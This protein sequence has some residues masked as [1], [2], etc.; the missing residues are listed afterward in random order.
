[1]SGLGRDL[2]QV[3]RGRVLVPGEEGFE[4]AGA[5]WNLAVRQRV[6]A[7]VEVADAA[8]AA[9]L[10][11]FAA[12]AE[13][14]LSTRATGHSPSAAADGTVLV[15]TRAL[16]EVEI[17][18][19]SR[20]ARVGA[21]VAWQPVLERAAVHGLAGA[22]GSSAVVGVAGYTLG[23]GV[24]WFARSRGYAAH[25]VRALNV[26]TADGD[27][28]RVTAESN[29]D[30]FWALRGGGGDFALVT[31]L[32]FE[33]FDAPELFGGRM[34]WPAERS[35]AV[36]AAFQ[37]ATAEAEAGLSLWLTLIQFPPFPQV[38]EPLRGQAMVAVD[39]VAVGAVTGP[40]RRF[41]EIAGLVLDTRRPLDAAQVGEVCMEPT[42]P[43]PARVRG[44]LLTDFSAEVGEALLA[45]AAPQGSVGPLALVQIRHLGGALA[46]PPADAGCA[47]GIAEPYLLSLLGP[48]PTPEFE[49]LVVE[50]QA[51]VVDAMRPHLSGRK[52]FTYLDSGENPAAVFDTETLARLR[53]IKARRDP[54]GLFRS[55][56]PVAPPLG[57][58]DPSWAAAPA[59]V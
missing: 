37:E 51:A 27:R 23:G 35:A 17:D 8:D 36:I 18:V 41:D 26:V 34:L 58:A 22:C 6:S 24:G 2:R 20:V 46:T 55:N 3:V 29:P 49:A 14:S 13:V 21:G 28:R 43:A 38:P 40:L 30:L 39:V 12:A 16:D 47:G 45:A 56:F 15:T 19:A 10:V 9:G 31:G 54:D 50:R 57:E 42:D 1:M 48:A 25:A 11:R 53:D 7:V 33:L 44:E 59:T 52:P 4:E 32:E 5:A